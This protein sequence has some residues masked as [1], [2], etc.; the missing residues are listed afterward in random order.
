MTQN[1]EDPSK[2]EDISVLSEH[3]YVFIFGWIF[4]IF[5]GRKDNHNSLDEKSHY[6]LL[7]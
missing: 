4:I 5:A 6:R 2:N 3:T 1:D 7:S